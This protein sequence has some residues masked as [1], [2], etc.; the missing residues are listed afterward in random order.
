MKEK[1]LKEPAVKHIPLT[2]IQKLIGK[3]MLASKLN[4]PCFYLSIKADVTEMMSLRP[5]LR[6]YL[7]V[8]ITTNCFY[9]RSLALACRKYP[10]MLGKLNGSSIKIPSHINVGFA[11]NASQG[12]VVPV[13]KNADE[14]SL[15]EIAK[16]EKLLTEKARDNNL[17]IEDISDEAIALSYLGP[18]AI[19]T[20]LAI[21]PPQTSAILAIGNITHDLIPKSG[22]TCERRKVSLTLAVNHKVIN[23][24]YAAKFLNQIKEYLQNPQQVI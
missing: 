9:I 21:V 7:G 6:K 1:N 12:L 11:V 2:R 18:Y 3:R 17:T 24:D 15:S 16:Q 5:K 23:G 20:F 13:L 19:D 8:K 10:L 14:K 22:G 4:N